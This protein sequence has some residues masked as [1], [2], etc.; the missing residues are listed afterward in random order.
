[1]MMST[2]RI[3][4]GSIAELSDN[5]FMRVAW[6]I[7]LVMLSAFVAVLVPRAAAPPKLAVLI[8]VDQMRADYVDRFRND[9]TAGLK[10]LVTRG[11]WFHRAAYPYFDTFT[12]PGHATIGTGAFPNRHGIFQNT[13]FDRGLNRDITCTEDATAQA[14]PYDTPVAG[15]DSAAKLLIPTFADEMRRQRSARVVSLALKARSAIMMVGH[16]GDA[17]TWLADSLEGWTTSTAYS[18]APVSAVSAFLASNPI[19]ADYGRTWIPVLPPDRHEG[20]DAGLGERPPLGWTHSFPHVLT[21][22][23]NEAKPTRAFFVQ[24]ETSPY[25]DAY[26][27]RM[28]AALVESMALGSKGTDVLAISFS[29]PDLVGHAFGPRSWE[30]REMYANLDRTL[31]SLFDRLDQLVGTDQ[32]VVGLSA[33]HGVAEIPE[34]LVAKG[35]DGGRVDIRAAV[36]TMEAAAQA[37]LGPGR[38]LLRVVGNDVYLA[39]GMFDRLLKEPGALERVVKAGESVPGIARVLRADQVAAAPAN[40][41]LLKA[42]ALS[43]TPN[44][45]GDLIFALKAGWMSGNI[46][47]THGSANPDDQRVPVILYG[48]GVKP[49]RYGDAATPADIAPTLAAICEITLPQAQGTVLKAALN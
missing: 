9:W 11:A 26:I 47:T 28:A 21:G 7:R 10:R 2:A 48:A 29:S 15:G 40:D 45:R 5:S 16:G 23:P 27:G 3:W 12:C 17:V 19:T 49:G 36:Q 34:Q 41:R 42:A 32:Y 39:A 14:V 35:R 33:D 6:S 38:Y 18:Q 25:A 24:W 44:R 22:D 43:Y 4:P 1:M 20:P 13:W 30:V 37:A 8:V 31:G 46:G